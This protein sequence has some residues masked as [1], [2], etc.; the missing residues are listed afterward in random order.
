MMDGPFD[1]EKA[2]NFA[3]CNGSFDIVGIAS[4]L[5]YLIMIQLI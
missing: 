2:S 3:L 4:K 5:K 1:T